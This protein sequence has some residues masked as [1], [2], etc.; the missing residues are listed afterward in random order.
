[1]IREAGVLDVD[2][3]VKIVPASGLRN[4]LVHQ[5]EKIDDKIVYNSVKMTIEDFSKYVDIISR[6]IGV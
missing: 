6:Y 5:Y 2:F 4:R 1:M 3:A